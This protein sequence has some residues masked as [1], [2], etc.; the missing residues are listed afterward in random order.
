MSNDTPT[1]GHCLCQAIQFEYLGEP[2][3]TLHCHCES[4]RRATSSPMT[5]WISVP[6]EAFRFV[7]GSPRYF[8][9]SPGA[10]RGFC[11][12]CGSP[13][14]FEHERIPGELHLYA[15]SLADPK[16]A[17]TPS[18]HVFVDEQLD[19]L[20]IHDELPRFATTSQGGAEPIC[21]GP[22]RE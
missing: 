14:T 2:N 21:Y 13:L 5:T 22:K 11:A 16:H 6:C 12:D 3:W 9:S 18:R 19:W 7:Q 4:C 20:E 15:A 10:R 17:V 8:E 1:S